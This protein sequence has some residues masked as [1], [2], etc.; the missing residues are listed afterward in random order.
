MRAPDVIRQLN[1]SC[2]RM[3]RST[4]R[5]NSPVRGASHTSGTRLTS[6]KSGGELDAG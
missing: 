5:A 3:Q 1:N 6:A 2:L 4:D